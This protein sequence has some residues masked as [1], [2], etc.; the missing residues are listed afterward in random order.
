MGDEMCAGDIQAH[1]LG[2]YKLVSYF[3]LSSANS[4]KSKMHKRET[5]PMTRNNGYLVNNH[6]YYH[7]LQRV[8]M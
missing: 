1:D 4:I 2:K 7:N 8:K 3:L 5:P 6:F